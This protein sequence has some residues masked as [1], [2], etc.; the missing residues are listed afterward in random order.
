MQAHSGHICIDLLA[1]DRFLVGSNQG[2]GLS[3]DTGSH[4]GSCHAREARH[5][6]PRPTTCGSSGLAGRPSGQSLTRPASV[7]LGLVLWSPVSSEGLPSVVATR[8]GVSPGDLTTA[9]ES[10]LE[11]LYERVLNGTPSYCGI[12]ML[13]ARVV[14]CGEI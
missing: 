4:E 3:A 9:A 13:L 5:S 12:G 11:S 1:F 6:I 8:C 2:S 14:T 10:Q 7:E